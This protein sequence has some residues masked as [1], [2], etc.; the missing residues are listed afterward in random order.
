MMFLSIF[1]ISG[2]VY[3]VGGGQ[4]IP[5]AKKKS[6]ILELNHSCADAFFFCLFV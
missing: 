5:L 6:E 4:N 3:M 2:D 1:S